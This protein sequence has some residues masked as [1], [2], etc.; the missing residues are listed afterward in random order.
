MDRGMSRRGWLGC[1]PALAFAA[2][3]AEV[4]ASTRSENRPADEPFGYCLNTS[5]I[6]GQKLPLVQEAELAAKAGYQAV[7][8]WIS[9][10]EQF[11]KD[12]GT[13]A[14][15]KK[16]IADLGLTIESV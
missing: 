14:D 7:E 13:L 9:E 1:V 11:Q 3:R 6:R 5:T 8:P 16:R 15:L 2:G 4:S 10:V 12:G